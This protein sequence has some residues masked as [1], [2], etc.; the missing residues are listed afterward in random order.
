LVAGQYQCFP[1]SFRPSALS[2]TSFDQDVYSAV[3]SFY[4]SL[5][6]GYRRFLFFIDGV[7]FF[8]A[9]SF[10][11]RYA[12]GCK[13]LLVVFPLEMLFFNSEF[14]ILAIHSMF[15]N[16]CVFCLEFV[17]VSLSKQQDS[18]TQTDRLFFDQLLE[19]RAFSNFLEEAPT[20][21]HVC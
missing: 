16:H 2:L 11:V 7:P 10:L 3:L 12:S 8:N 14:Q 18:S 20:P 4:S 19:S 9:T 1:G 17:F 6:S 15:V 13:K 5:L 21:F